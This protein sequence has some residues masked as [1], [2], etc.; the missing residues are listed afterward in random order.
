MTENVTY[1]LRLPVSLR[2]EVVK[3]AKRD[4]TSVNQL[5]V[6]AVAEKISTLKTEEFFKE[7][8]LL[9]DVNKFKGILYRDD[10]AIPSKG[11]ESPDL[12]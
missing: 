1:P 7:R 9:T 11:D 3:V 6:T 2:N 4:G 12:V 5:I 10:G 8:R